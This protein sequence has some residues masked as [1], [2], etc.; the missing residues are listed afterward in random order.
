MIA[1]LPCINEGFRWALRQEDCVCVY[2]SNLCLFANCIMLVFNFGKCGSVCNHLEGVVANFRWVV[3]ERGSQIG[4]PRVPRTDG[5]RRS[6]IN[7]SITV[8][9]PKLIRT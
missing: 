5:C 6:K 3:C 1:D 9:T 4:I 8:G 7:G 2:R